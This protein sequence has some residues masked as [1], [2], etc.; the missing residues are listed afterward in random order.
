M[1]AAAYDLALMRTG[2]LMTPGMSEC[3]L[4]AVEARYGFTFAR[5]HR[6][7][8]SVALPLDAV[9]E[10]PRPLWP[11][12]RQPDKHLDEQVGWPVH[13]LLEDC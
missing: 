4:Q 1:L 7:M 3:E 13:G 12:W 8:L 5:E 6:L 2:A 10:R 9:P 11:N